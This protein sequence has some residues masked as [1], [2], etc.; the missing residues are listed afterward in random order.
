LSDLPAESWPPHSAFKDLSHFAQLT[1][2]RAR[3]VGVAVCD[4]SSKVRTSFLQ[5][6]R[7]HFF[8]EWEI[9]REIQVPSAG[10]ELLTEAQLVVHGKNTFQFATPVPHSV[11]GGSRLNSYFCL[12][13][14]VAPG[15]YDFCLGLAGTNPES[16]E[17]YVRGDLSH[18][19]FSTRTWTHCR[20]I[21]A[22]SL[23]VG[24]AAFGKLSHHGL[25][26]LP[27]SGKLQIVAGP[28]DG[29]SSVAEP[30]Q[31]PMPP[32]F[33]ITHWKA[34]SQWIYKILRQCVLDRIIEPRLGETQVRH[35]AIQRGRVYPTVYMTK[36]DFTK[37]VPPDSK[38]FVVIRDLRDTLISA[39]FSFKHSHPTL[40]EGMV[41]LR[42]KLVELDQEDALLYLMEDFLSRCAKIQLSWVEAETPILKYEELLEDDFG[43]LERTLIQECRLPVRR[44][45]LRQA[46]LDNR[47]ESLTQGRK[48]GCEGILAHE[49]KGIAGDWQNYFTP[50]LTS[51]FKAR[52]G[53]LLVATG[54]ERDL[55]W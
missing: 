16:Y 19:E 14:R 35:H 12:E 2:G 33:H 24:Y 13:L 49:R 11:R 40:D 37:A 51:A 29:A 18:A 44:E 8:I 27:G 43:I 34:G 20:V 25:A 9:I 4:D 36:E 32:V 50:K 46:I 7:A 54:Y 23:Q 17:G 52:Y 15:K 48:R 22:G 1:D 41:A 47:F 21:H 45:D 31:D 39:Y 26:D 6:E 38:H 55:C 28:T 42:R 3:C 10:L 30:A 53:G 5:G